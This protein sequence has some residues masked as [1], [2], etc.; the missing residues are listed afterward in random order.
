MKERIAPF[1]VSSAD[2]CPIAVLG[3]RSADYPLGEGQKNIF[4][5]LPCKISA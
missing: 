4:A 1:D 2:L 3:N 5:N